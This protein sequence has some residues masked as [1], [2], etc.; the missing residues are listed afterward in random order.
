MDVVPEVAIDEDMQEA[1]AEDAEDHGEKTEVDEGVR[2]E[3]VFPREPG[4]QP[5]R[6][7]EA[8]EQEREVRRDRLPED[9]RERREH[10]AGL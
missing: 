3:P 5:G 4:G 9:L 10:L 2:V 1:S 8:D 6:Q 7:G